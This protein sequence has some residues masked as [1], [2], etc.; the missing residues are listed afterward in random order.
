MPPTPQTSRTQSGNAEAMA[1]QV[2]L[3]RVPYR[4]RAVPTDRERPSQAARPLDD[5]ATEVVHV[6]RFL[7]PARGSSVQPVLWVRRELLH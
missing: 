3:P 5:G 7:L 1:D 6:I 2:Q 4:Q